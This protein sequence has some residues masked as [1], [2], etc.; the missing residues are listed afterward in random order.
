MCSCLFISK[1]EG[2]EMKIKDIEKEMLRLGLIE[3]SVDLSTEWFGREK[4]YV[5]GLKNAER[6]PSPQV[7]ARCAVKLRLT[8]RRFERSRRN[9][10]LELVPKLYRLAELCTAAMFRIEGIKLP[11]KVEE[12]AG[13]KPID[14]LKAQKASVAAQQKQLG[15]RKKQIAAQSAQQ[16]NTRAQQALTAAR[17]KP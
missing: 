1:F 4:S 17:S 14:P 3:S 6:E 7:L 11:S 8:A 10:I 12:L 9:H 5:R 16:K 13:S 15:I 2:T